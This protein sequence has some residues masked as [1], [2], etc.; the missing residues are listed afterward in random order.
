MPDIG[1]RDRIGNPG[2]NPATNAPLTKPPLP[3]TT[4]G[5]A[6]D[7]D[8]VLL[9]IRKPNGTRLIFG[10]PTAAQDGL[11]IREDVGRF[12]ADITYDQG[13][14]WNYRLEGTGAV[15]AAEEGYV[16]VTYSATLVP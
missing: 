5:V 6:T 9:T 4:G 15:V 1:D 10:W 13:G 7:P 12:Y 3:F 8:A 11:L 14:T 2:I 16:S